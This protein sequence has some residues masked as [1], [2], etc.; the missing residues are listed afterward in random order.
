[1][2]LLKPLTRQ[3]IAS[4]LSAAQAVGDDRIQKQATGHINQDNWTHGSS[5]ERQ[6]WFTTGYQSGD[7]NSCDT[8]AA[9]SL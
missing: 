7:L 1:M 5:A 6:R 9:T 8:F 3:D 4:A 2:T